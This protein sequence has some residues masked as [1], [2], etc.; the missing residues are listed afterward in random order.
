MLATA[1]KSSAP[2]QHAALLGLMHGHF[3]VPNPNEDVVADEETPERSVHTGIGVVVPV[4][5]ILETVRHPELI[6]TRQALVEQVRKA[7]D[8]RRSARSGR[9]RI[10]T[11]CR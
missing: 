1:L 10:E 2:Q 9:K 5:K 3:D 6:A 4:H 7:S 8:R 11:R